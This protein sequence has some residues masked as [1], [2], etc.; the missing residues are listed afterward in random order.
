MTR[1]DRCSGREPTNIFLYHIAFLR[2]VAETRQAVGERGERDDRSTITRFSARACVGGGGVGVKAVCLNCS[3][4]SALV[5]LMIM[6]ASHM[7]SLYGNDDDDDD[8]DDG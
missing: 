8:D 6:A 5:K 1:F 7:L 2:F 3:G 4:T